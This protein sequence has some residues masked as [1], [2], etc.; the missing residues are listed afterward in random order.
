MGSS[1]TSNGNFQTEKS[2]T[3][4]K[5]KKTQKQNY[6]FKEDSAIHLKTAVSIAIWSAVTAAS[7]FFFLGAYWVFDVKCQSL[8]IEINDKFATKV[9]LDNAKI[10]IEKQQ[11]I[12]NCLKNKNGFYINCLK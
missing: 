10:Q 6:N 7:A 11:F 1:T 9:D 4:N 2:K 3:F 8:K 5:L 12:F